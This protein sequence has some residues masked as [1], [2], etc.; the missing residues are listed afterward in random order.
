[1]PPR[2][3]DST[4]SAAVVLL[5]VCARR[6]VSV[7]PG[8]RASAPLEYHA[9]ADGPA[10]LL[11]QKPLEPSPRPRPRARAGNGRRRGPRAASLARRKQSAGRP[12]FAFPGIGS[13]CGRHPEDPRSGRRGVGWDLRPRHAR[14]HLANAE[15]VGMPSPRSLLVETVAQTRSVGADSNGRSRGCRNGGDSLLS[16]RCVRHVGA[17]PGGRFHNEIAARGVCATASVQSGRVVR[18]SRDTCSSSVP[19]ARRSS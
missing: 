4:T 12:N 2:T 14:V 10:R 15:A 1:M 18:P 8:S 19:V 11:R 17:R 5:R 9:I 6:N 16:F 3:D 13:L 7:S